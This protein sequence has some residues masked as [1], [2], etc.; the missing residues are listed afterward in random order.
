MKNL[1]A[2]LSAL[3]LVSAAEPMFCQAG[4]TLG[5]SF[6]P[7]SRNIAG[8]RMGGVSV[9]VAD[10]I[11]QPLGNPANLASLKRPFLFLSLNNA[12]RKF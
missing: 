9:A 12:S 10:N 5:S 8:R 1:L 3:L 6:P 2:F 11:P 4:S 7:E